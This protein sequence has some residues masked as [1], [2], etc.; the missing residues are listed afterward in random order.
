MHVEYKNWQAAEAKVAEAKAA[1]EKLYVAFRAN[2]NKRPAWRNA[3]W[4]VL[5]TQQA[6]DK[7]F[8][9]YLEARP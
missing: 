9:A 1:E 6:A 8:A 3:K 2:I 5:F 7:A 4:D